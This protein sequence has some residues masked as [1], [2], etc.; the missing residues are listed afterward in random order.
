ML[1]CHLMII[2]LL[3]IMGKGSTNLGGQVNGER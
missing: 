2:Y 1:N 3:G